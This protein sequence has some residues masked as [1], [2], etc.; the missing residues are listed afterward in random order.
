MAGGWQTRFMPA[1]PEG[2]GYCLS[3][4]WKGIKGDYGLQ[5]M[6]HYG[7]GNFESISD[8]PW[9]GLLCIGRSDR[10]EG[11]RAWR[12]GHSTCN[13]PTIGTR[14]LGTWAAELLGD[15]NRGWINCNG[16]REGVCLIYNYYYK[17][18]VS[19]TTTT[20]TTITWRYVWGIISLARN[21]LWEV[22][23]GI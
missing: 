15:Y 16:I 22:H 5:N 3:R 1:M 11:R 20:Y 6:P 14:S 21:Y 18:G 19:Y 12:D 9:R 13:R 7:P 8:E 4:L 17:I 2:A 10:G 23:R